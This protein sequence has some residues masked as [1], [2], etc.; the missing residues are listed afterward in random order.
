MFVVNTIL[1]FYGCVTLI[2]CVKAV[3][4]Q[5]EMRMCMIAKQS[6]TDR[7]VGP[8]GIFGDCKCFRQEM[9]CPKFWFRQPR[10][11]CPGE[12]RVIEVPETYTDYEIFREERI[13]WNEIHKKAVVDI[14][15]QKYEEVMLRPP[16]TFAETTYDKP[17]VFPEPEPLIGNP[18]DVDLPPLVGVPIPQEVIPEPVVKKVTKVVKKPP[19]M[20]VVK[21]TMIKKAPVY[22]T[23]RIPVK[24]FIT[25]KRPI[26]R[27]RIHYKKVLVEHI[28]CCPNLKFWFIDLPVVV[29]NNEVYDSS[30]GVTRN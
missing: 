20:G 29:E 7:P 9:G 23:E 10:N 6:L 17:N 4:M 8:E 18:P 24:T 2:C 30:R 5:Y 28:N 3:T 25:K 16:V 1:V 11:V 13:I 22:K 27:V 14:P 19:V 15:V 26:Q 12:T 21:K